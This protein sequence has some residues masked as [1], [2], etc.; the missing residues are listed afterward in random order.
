[1]ARMTVRRTASCSLSAGVVA[2]VP[3]TMKDPRWD[4]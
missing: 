4:P 2:G 1:M 3:L